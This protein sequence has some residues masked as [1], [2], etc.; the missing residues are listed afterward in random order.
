M[1]Y[2]AD[3]GE[4]FYYSNSW[5]DLLSLSEEELQKTAEVRIQVPDEDQRRDEFW[6]F[7]EKLK[8]KTSNLQNITKLKADVSYFT[9][10]VVKKIAECF[11]YLKNI[12]AHF[13]EFSAGAIAAFQNFQYLHTLKIND[14]RQKN[15]YHLQEFGNLK[16]LR[17]LIID[18]SRTDCYNL[19]SLAFLKSMNLE[20][21]EIEGL[22]SAYNP[23][24]NGQFNRLQNNNKLLQREKFLS[25][26]METASPGK[27]SCLKVAAELFFRGKI[28][29]GIEYLYM[30]A[31]DDREEIPAPFTVSHDPENREVLLWQWNDNEKLTKEYFLEREFLLKIYPDTRTELKDL[32]FY[33]RIYGRHSRAKHKL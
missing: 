2:Q 15:Y 10:D 13:S 22:L 16:Q 21:L 19:D 25:K 6:N 27:S 33:L 24:V 18:N 5:R 12:Y 14:F 23:V 9:P 30:Y 8:S 1:I 32:D 7:L 26:T 4:L 20:K 3:N 11:P 17:V 31:K 29:Q 28:E